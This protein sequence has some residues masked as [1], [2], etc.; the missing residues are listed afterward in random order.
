MKF[1]QINPEEIRNLP[2]ETVNR[3]VFGDWADDGQ[4]GDVALLLG[5]NPIVLPDRAK[6]AADLYFAGRVRHIVP[7]GGVEWDSDRGRMTEAEYLAACL[8]DLGVPAEA[9]ILEN[10]ARTTPENMICGTLQI[11]RTLKINNI[12]KIFIVTS[13][14][15]L[16]R[17]LMYAYIFLPRPVQ[18]AGYADLNAPC[19]PENWEKDPFY[20]NRVYREAELTHTAV[21]R[22]WFPDIELD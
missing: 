6:A 8:A 5:G 16:R 7:T 19:G 1:S 21:C 15:H 4:P 22:G 12:R 3:I 10:E 17:S 13:P 11:M 14:S 20:A 9:V 2:K 18:F